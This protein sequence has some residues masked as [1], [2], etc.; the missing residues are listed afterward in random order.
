MLWSDRVK[1]LMTAKGLNQLQLAEASGITP[2]SV[3]RYLSGGRTPRIDIIINF[4]KALD[5]STQY[6]LG[7]ENDGHSAFCEISEAI[8]RQ[9]NELTPEEKNKLI[10]LILGKGE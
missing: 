4:A 3:S 10:A 8:A 6:L 2:A 7:E 9:G 1:E 5:V